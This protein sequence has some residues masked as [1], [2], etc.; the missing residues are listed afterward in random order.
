MG[1]IYTGDIGTRLRHT[2][3]VDLTGYSSIDYKIKKPSGTVLTKTCVVEDLS[4][5]IIYYDIIAGDIDEEG[6]YLI[7]GYIQF[8]SGNKNYSVTET[9]TVHNLFK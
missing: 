8:A 2:L 1:K 6:E 7:Q 3:N 9:F 4:E 5:G